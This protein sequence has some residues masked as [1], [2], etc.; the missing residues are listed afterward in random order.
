[1]WCY[2]NDRIIF[3][4]YVLPFFFLYS[5]S[6]VSSTFKFAE[7]DT[8]MKADPENLVN[9]AKKV[10]DWLLKQRWKKLARSSVS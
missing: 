3:H 1:M 10:I 9:M 6:C 5:H 8:I 4:E 2:L 7:F